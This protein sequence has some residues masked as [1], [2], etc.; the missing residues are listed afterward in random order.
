MFKTIL[1]ANDGSGPA[2]KA[3]ELARDLAK[4]NK[5]ELQMASVEEV[6]S[7]P[8]PI[9]E[10]ETE[11]QNADHRYKHVLKRA[12]AMAKEKGVTL[13][14]HV[15]IGHPQRSIAGELG[16]DLLVIGATAIRRCM[17]ECSEAGPTGSFSWHHA[18]FWS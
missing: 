5:S 18:P 3:L 9:G 16:A 11:R 13:E 12:K 1:N 7:F 6:A 2:F 8:E 10:V 15:L 4:Q 14:T 17:K